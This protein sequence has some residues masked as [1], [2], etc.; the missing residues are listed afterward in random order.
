MNLCIHPAM[1]VSQAWLAHCVPAPFPRTARGALVRTGRRKTSVAAGSGG[2]LRLG[3]QLPEGSG[4]WKEHAGAL[5]VDGIILGQGAGSEG[6]LL[7]PRGGV[8]E[9]G[10]PQRGEQ[11]PRLARNDGTGE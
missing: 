4:T 10:H 11:Q 9:G 1:V 2:A 6:P 8:V 5:P 7:Q 3:E